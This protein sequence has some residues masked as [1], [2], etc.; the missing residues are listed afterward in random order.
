VKSVINNFLNREQTEDEIKHVFEESM[1]AYLGCRSVVPVV[2]G[3]IALE[4]ALRGLGLCRGD[5]VIVPDISFIATA[6]AVANCGLIPVFADVS[7]DY[8]GLTVET[9]R[10]RDCSRVKAALL[11]HFSG[12]VNRDLFEIIEYCCRR[13]LAL[14]EDCAQAFACTAFGR[15][16][17]T[18]GDAGIFSF[19]SSKIINAGEGGLVCTDKQ[20][21]AAEFQAI[22]DWGMSPAFV[23]RK[24]ELPSSNFRLSALQ[25]Y[26]LQQ[27]LQHIE[28]T[29]AARLER[30]RE[31]EN[32]CR[33]LGLEHRL[34]AGKTD[35][36]DCPFFFPVKSERKL[37][38]IEPREESPMHRSAIVPAILQHF[39]PDLLEIYYELNP[40]ETLAGFASNNII[41]DIDFIN[42]HQTRNLPADQVMTAYTEA[43]LC[44]K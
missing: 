15:K 1:A 18:F 3:T 25:C 16:V 14:V 38:T 29:M 17:G 6:T 21:L 19:Q 26:W 35:F 31:L 41:S 42:I 10:N 40:P 43:A 44:L 8:F 33:N 2:N 9:L 28:H 7:P 39:F 20:N 12:F 34:P 13:D 4:V 5:A 23:K 32:A 30:C 24:L 22:S 11:V 37:N 36:V 27:K